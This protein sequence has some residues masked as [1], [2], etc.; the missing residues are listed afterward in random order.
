MT[1]TR[2]IPVEKIS[3]HGKSDDQGNPETFVSNVGKQAIGERC[4]EKDAA[5]AQQV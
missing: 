2:K 5:Q 1:F 3:Q 4:H